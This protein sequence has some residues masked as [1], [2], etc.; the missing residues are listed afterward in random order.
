MNMKFELNLAD[1]IRYAAVWYDVEEPL[2]TSIQ[3]GDHDRVASL[4]RYLIYMRVRRDFQT[5]KEERILDLSL[6]FARREDDQAVLDLSSRFAEENILSG[7]KTR[8]I[9]A[10]SKILWIMNRRH[11]IMDSL[12]QRALETI[13]GVKISD[14]LS[15][16]RLWRDCFQLFKEYLAKSESYEA[17]TKLDTIF[18]AEWFMARTCDLYLWRIGG[19]SE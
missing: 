18:S 9:V 17:L 7:R 4:Q 1:L 19:E 13:L 8:A 2:L 5:G 15:Y 10:A 16:C 6:P 3:L 14:Y 12:S 11:I